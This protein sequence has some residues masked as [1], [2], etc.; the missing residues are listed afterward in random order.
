MDRIVTMYQTRYPETWIEASEQKMGTF[1]IKRGESVGLDSPLTPFHMNADG[2]MW[3]S[4]TVR[5]WTSFGYT[6]P[7]LID[8]PSNETFTATLNKLY[9]PAS[10][11]LNDTDASVSALDIDGNKTDTQVTDWSCQVNMPSDIK[12]S[13]SVNAF[14]GDPPTNPEDWPTSSNY[15]GQLAS[16]SSARMKTD[17]IITGNIGLSERLAQKYQSGELKSMEKVDVAAYLKDNFHWRIQALDFTEI[18]RNNPPAGL[19]VTVYNVPVK[20]PESDTQVPTQETKD[21]QYNHDIDGNPP[22]YNGPGIDGTNSTAPA[23]PV[24]GSYNV[25]SGEFE[26]RNAKHDDEQDGMSMSMSM[27]SSSSSW[28]TQFISRSQVATEPPAPVATNAP[29]TPPLDLPGLPDPLAPIMSIITSVAS[30]I[31][32]AMTAAPDTTPAPDSPGGPQTRYVTEVV[33]VTM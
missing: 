5:N 9:K 8:S 17:V 12:I 22:I 13:Y 21:I 19:N 27:S 18:P 26:W 10:Q 15:I 25:T 16:M 2:D 1:T 23:S 28:S 33:V 11:G 20:I 4:R 30:A 14:L 24:G 6:Y 31:R 29:D 3:T 7:E 32:P